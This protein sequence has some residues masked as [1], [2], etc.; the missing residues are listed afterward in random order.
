MPKARWSQAHALG[1]HMRLITRA[2]V[3]TITCIMYVC[4]YVS[5]GTAQFKLYTHVQNACACTFNACKL[6]KLTCAHTV[7]HFGAC[8][9]KQTHTTHKR[10][11]S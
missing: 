11:M 4:I 1:I 3:T 7:A 5:Y 6:Q 8:T 2:Y 10:C 9:G